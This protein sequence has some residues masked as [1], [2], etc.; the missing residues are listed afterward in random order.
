MS[1]QQKYS[2]LVNDLVRRL[3]NINKNIVSK[4]EIPRM[5]EQFIQMPVTSVYDRKQSIED[6][7]CGIRGWKS[8]IRRR[9]EEG[10]GFYTPATSTLASRYRKKLTAK[11][12]C[13]K[14]KKKNNQKR[15]HVLMRKKR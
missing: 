11:T 13:Y 12:S 8:K 14:T 7:V 10:K 15:N 1:N 6:L 3:S 2:I 4:E 9:E 5:T